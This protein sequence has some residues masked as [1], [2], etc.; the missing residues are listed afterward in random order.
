MPKY[1]VK[2][3]LSHDGKDYPIGSLV[4]MDE[5]V[6]AQLVGT[7]EPSAASAPPAPVGPTDPVVRLADIKAAIGMLD[8]NNKDSWTKSGLPNMDSLEGQLGWRPTAVERDQAW[9]E[10]TPPA[11]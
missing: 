10:L 5:K 8:P 7:V 2:S 3:P 4:E 11:A 9:S 1:T 6:A